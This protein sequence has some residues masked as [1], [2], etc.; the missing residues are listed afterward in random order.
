MTIQ[1]HTG[2]CLDVLRG[3][4]SGSVDAVVTDPPYGVDF[5]SARRT[6]SQRFAKIA[7]DKT[8]FVWWLYDAARVLKD[9]GC[10]VCFCR[11]DVAEAFRAA[12]GWAGLTVKTQLVWDRENHGL[13]DLKG[14]PAPRHDLL[15]FAVKGKYALP[16]KRP[17][18]VYRATRL[19][20]SQLQ[21]PNQKP[22]E[23]MQAIVRDY[24]SPGG[25]VLDPFM[26]SGT[27]GVACKLEGRS[28]IGVEREPEYV[29][30]ARQR[31][32][33]A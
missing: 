26:G 19:A 30:T 28:F 25:T 11:W 18:S 9:G 2:D 33:A 6:E 10:L 23:L 4:E 31:I 22:V 29:E 14:S 13:G 5:Q 12:I 21:H 7:N 15:W 24:C 27:T 20:G 16:G 17:T 32:E 3:L 8:P 1:L